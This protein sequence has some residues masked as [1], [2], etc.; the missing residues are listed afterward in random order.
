MVVFNGDA[1][2][3]TFARG[4]TASEATAIH[5][6]RWSTGEVL[7][8]HPWTGGMGCA[9]VKDGAIHIFGNTNFQNPGNKI[10]HS[11]LAPDFTPSSPVDAL[12]DDPAKPFKFYNTDVT[13]DA[14][15]FRMVVET[16]A[17]VFFATSPDL[18]TWTW[19]SGQLKPG[20]Y[21][22]CPTIDYIGGEH[23]LTF[24]EPGPGGT[25]QTATAK[26]TDGCLSF[27]YGKVLLAPD[28]SDVINCSDVDMV[29]VGDKVCGVYLDGDQ[30]THGDLCR[31]SF[32]GTLAQ[33]FAPCF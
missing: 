14:S 9:I 1:L 21:C 25:W 12:L 29:E 10:I 18:M 31:W 28:T 13:A 4:V 3:I 30:S 22:G 5:V 17:G 23:C 15:G 2:A 19:A 32:N 20:E 26:S 24:L 27:S 8:E 33:M 16:T 6:R 7:A 11:V